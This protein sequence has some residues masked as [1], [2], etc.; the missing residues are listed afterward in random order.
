MGLGTGSH[1]RTMTPSALTPASSHDIISE[2][3]R[4]MKD[5]LEPLYKTVIP[6]TI[7]RV[8]LHRDDLSR[9][10]GIVPKIID[11]ARGALSSEIAKMNQAT[12]GQKLRIARPRAMVE[13]PA[14]DWII[15]LLENTD[16]DTQPGDIVIYSELALPAKPEYSGSLTKR[17]ET[18]RLGKATETK[19][20]PRENAGAEV[21][22]TIEYED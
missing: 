18:R 11:E 21:Y 12:L 1:R 16:Q 8:Y 4:N 17:T 6:P 5:G 19:A 9:I 13:S 15:E 20:A 14:G 10:S 3:L 7:Y 2:I 22:A